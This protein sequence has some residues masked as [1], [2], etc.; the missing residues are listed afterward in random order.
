MTHPPHTR[1]VESPPAPSVS[2]YQT[3]TD[4]TTPP[5]IYFGMMRNNRMK[6]R[7]MLSANP[8]PPYCVRLWWQ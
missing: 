1:T 3:T 7:P 2:T 4:L 6:P 5:T 8:A